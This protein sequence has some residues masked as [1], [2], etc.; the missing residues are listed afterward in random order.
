MPARLL[1][2][3]SNWKWQP[4]YGIV[5]FTGAGCGCLTEEDRDR[6]WRRW[7]V[8]VFEQMLGTDGSV[9]A[10]ECDAHQ[11]L[12]LRDGIRWRGE[13]MRDRCPCGVATP[14]IPA[15]IGIARAVAAFVPAFAAAD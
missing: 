3:T 11:G 10:E 5:V 1:S 2:L 12:H 14:R 4:A 8:P 15:S 13:L 6:V 7:G 9:A